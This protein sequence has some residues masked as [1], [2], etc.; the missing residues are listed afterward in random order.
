MITKTNKNSYG[1]TL[2]ETL[3]AVA[4]LMVAIAGPLTIANQAL[5]AAL[6]ARNAMIASNL[7]QDG[8]ESIKNVKDNNVAL[9]Q[10]WTQGWGDAANCISTSPCAIPDVFA[11]LPPFIHTCGYYNAANFTG[12]LLYT[13]DSGPTYYKYFYTDS[14]TSNRVSPFTRYYFLTPFPN[15]TTPTEMI[16]TVVVSWN[17]GALPN[18]IRL[19]ELMTNAAR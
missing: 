16:V 3:I 2:V 15:A 5:T 11:N 8:M 10:T 6:G 17:D 13:N 9:N 14:P 7:A 19:Q 18:E 12:C 1:F 4:I